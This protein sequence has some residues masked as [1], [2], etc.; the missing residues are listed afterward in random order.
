MSLGNINRGTWPSGFGCW[1]QIEIQR[2]ENWM[3][4]F[5][6]SL[7]GTSNERTNQKVRF[8][9]DDDFYFFLLITL[10]TKWHIQFS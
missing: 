3:V 10:R 9:D 6:T 2:S 1:I 8:A 5:K 4:Q 7:A